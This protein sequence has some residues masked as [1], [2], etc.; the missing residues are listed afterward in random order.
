MESEIRRAA[1]TR[2]VRVTLSSGCY[3]PRTLMTPVLTA[4]AAPR[5]AAPP[6]DRYRRSGGMRDVYGVLRGRPPSRR[7]ARRTGPAVRTRGTFT[8][9][10]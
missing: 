10:R 2:A 8:H 6:A 9:P 5:A 3:V 4:T 7:D 1:L